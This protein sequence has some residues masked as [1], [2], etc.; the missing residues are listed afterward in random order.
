VRS[1][2]HLLG[3]VLVSLA[4]SGLL[5]GFVSLGRAQT[6]TDPL[7]DCLCRCACSAEGWACEQEQVD[8]YHFPF[9]LTASPECSNPALGDCVCRGF[10]CGRARLSF[11][12]ACPEACLSG[13]ATPTASLPTAP[14][15]TSTPPPTLTRAVS[16]SPTRSPVEGSFDVFARG[17][18][19]CSIIMNSSDVVATVRALGGMSACANDDCDRD[20]DVDAADAGCA[21]RCLFGACPVPSHAPRIL[22]VE[23]VTAS[24]I[25]AFSVIWLTAD[26]LVE[27]DVPRSI[28]VGARRGAVV[29]GVEDGGIL[30]VVPNVPAGATSI[31]LADG[32]IEGAPFAIEIA[33]AQ[34]FSENGGLADL[35]DAISGLVETVLALDV[36]AAYGESAEV[37]RRELEA[38]RL[39]LP[40]ALDAVTGEPGYGGEAGAQLNLWIDASGIAATLRRITGELDAAVIFEPGDPSLQRMLRGAG[41]MVMAA[42]R[43]TVLAGEEIATDGGGAGG[44]GAARL[45]L[46]VAALGARTIAGGVIAAAGAVTTWTIDTPVVRSISPNPIEPGT[47][48]TLRGAGFGDTPRPNLILETEHGQR[49]EIPFPVVEEENEMAFLIPKSTGVCGR[50]NVYLQRP[51]LGG[52]IRSRSHGFELAIR[53]TI[54]EIIDGP[55]APPRQQRVQMLA[56]GIGY[57]PILFAF[58]CA[59]F[60]QREGERRAFCMRRTQSGTDRTQYEVPYVVPG[61][62][63]VT[64]VRDGI[65][66]ERAEPLTIESSLAPEIR[67]NSVKIEVGE[68]DACVADLDRARTGDQQRLPTGAVDVEWS[69]EPGDVLSPEP[70]DLTF[71]LSFRGAKVGLADLGFSLARTDVTPERKFAA[72]SVTIEVVQTTPPTLEVIRES[73]MQIRPGD[74]IQV[75]A[76]ARAAAGAKMKELRL[77]AGGAAVAA[78]DHVHDETCDGF[79]PGFPELGSRDCSEVFAVQVR[80]DVSVAEMA[81]GIVVRVTAVDSFDN[82]SDPV[83]LQYFFAGGSIGG[84]V[85]DAE[86]GEP[87]AGATVQL[88]DPSNVLIDEI[89]AGVDGFFFGDVPAGSYTIRASASGYRTASETVTLEP[90]Q[91]LDVTILLE[92]QAPPPPLS[93]EVEQIAARGE[94]APGTGGTFFNF[95]DYNVDQGLVVFLANLTSVPGNAVFVDDGS[96]RLLEQGSFSDLS[97]S[98]GF[99]GFASVRGLYHRRESPIGTLEDFVH[100]PTGTSEFGSFRGTQYDSGRLAFNISRAP[101]GLE[102]IYVARGP[103]SPENTGNLAL[104]ADTSFEVPGPGGPFFSLSANRYELAFDADAGDRVA[105]IGRQTSTEIEGVYVGSPGASLTRVADNTMGFT[106]P[107]AVA[108]E[109]R[110]VA[111]VAQEGV[112]LWDPDATPNL[113]TLVDTNTLVRDGGGRTFTQF[114][115]RVAM[116]GGVVAFRGETS[117]AGGTLRGVYAHAN[118]GVITILR[119]DADNPTVGTLLLEDDQS[120]SA[121]ND[122]DSRVVDI[123]FGNAG[124]VYRATLGPLAPG[125]EPRNQDHPAAR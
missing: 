12:G 56:T 24:E 111:F 51:Q 2:K 59:K 23:P 73:P 54:E 42:G 39:D 26:N 80:A 88:R 53:P 30:V 82:E 94:A 115:C 125:R 31:V 92:A 13:A 99:A 69:I 29:D 67:C 122:G 70:S 105:F 18:A 22:S 113:S 103:I 90:D 45:D 60:R 123:V 33:A 86:T 78:G 8:C 3:R 61:A 84:A 21:A 75:T 55:V 110:R 63:E 96:V 57:C 107:C 109:G 52:L 114:A 11:A 77:R 101:S 14:L 28:R 9:V 106:R 89:A 27:D 72:G 6:G 71:F 79:V 17:D 62:Y 83:E 108:V 4:L 49:I 40:E 120:I 116:D 87:I 102:T 38:L 34:S 58:D 121:R 119:I 1:L 97:I 65:E 43:A 20:G 7:L 50:M 104:V 68:L 74:E 10:G 81:G 19:D 93:V 32:E 48:L 36:G 37:V 91:T 47:R 85:R 15:P 64:L 98:D 76:R 112:F 5:P 41:R 16:P 35:V 46:G 118:G 117:G 95:F 124:A 66:S 25:R 44:G 100:L